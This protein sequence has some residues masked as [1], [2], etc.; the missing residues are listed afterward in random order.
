ML[1][2]HENKKKVTVGRRKRRRI[3]RRERRKTWKKEGRKHGSNCCVSGLYD[4]G[5][6][7]TGLP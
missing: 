3:W 2:N 4:V 6:K 7:K 5:V 1:T